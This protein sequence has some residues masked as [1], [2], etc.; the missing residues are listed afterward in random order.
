MIRTSAGGLARANVRVGAGARTEPGADS[1]LSNPA[2]PWHFLSRDRFGFLRDAPR[3]RSSRVWRTFIAWLPLLL[4]VGVGCVGGQ[5]GTEATDDDRGGS[6]ASNGG[7]PAIG[8]DA[9]AG[10]EGTA[11]PDAPK[12]GSASG[13]DCVAISEPDAERIA[14]AIDR[15]SAT[16]AALSPEHLLDQGGSTQEVALSIHDAGSACEAPIGGGPSELRIDVTLELAATDGSFLLEFP[17]TAQFTSGSDGSLLKLELT[18]AL[19]CTGTPGFCVD[20]TVF[21]GTLRCT[22]LRGDVAAARRDGASHRA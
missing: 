1:T 3:E 15:A 18:G 7:T 9:S 22:A 20:V 11:T 21:M 19:H 14:N 13:D 5:T 17:G 6:G 8:S 12:D 2:R 16:L 4:T 10:S